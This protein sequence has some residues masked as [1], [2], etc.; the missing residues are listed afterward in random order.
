[1]ARIKFSSIITGMDGSIGGTTFQRSKVGY[2]AR[3]KVHGKK[4]ITDRKSVNMAILN[5]CELA[6]QNASQGTR[7]FWA[8]YAQRMRFPANLVSGRVLSGY[9]LFLRF[10]YWRLQ[11]GQSIA[12]SPGLTSPSTFTP[13]MS[14]SIGPR[15]LVLDLTSTYTWWEWYPII[16]LTYVVN[17]S[18]TNPGGRYRFINI[19]E[20]SSISSVI[21]D[22]YVSVFGRN[23]Q[24]DD[25]VFFK[26]S[27]FNKVSGRIK[28][29]TSSK[30]VLEA[31]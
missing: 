13:D 16:Y 30:V 18:I 7:D 31:S 26:Y 24:I 1:M 10:N 5:N 8:H 4:F 22:E 3:N 9:E 25:I 14:L 21:D 6:W 20:L 23:L 11:F 12:I 15:G 19:G 17:G 28:P 29:Y 2:I 27:W